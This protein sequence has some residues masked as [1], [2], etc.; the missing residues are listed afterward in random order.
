MTTLKP[1]IYVYKEYQG[2]HEI[3]IIHETNRYP[4]IKVRCDQS[5]PLVFLNNYVTVI[6]EKKVSDC[7]MYKRTDLGDVKLNIHKSIA[8]YFIINR[9]TIVYKSN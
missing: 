1:K 9:E 2:T 5:L 8:D 3:N 4:P 7:N 6:W